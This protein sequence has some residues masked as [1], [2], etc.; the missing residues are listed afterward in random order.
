[1][2]CFFVYFLFQ[3]WQYSTLPRA[4]LWFHLCIDCLFSCSNNLHPR[5]FHAVKIQ[6]RS[7]FIMF[8]DTCNNL[9]PL[10]ENTS[11]SSRRGIQRCESDA[12]SLCLSY[13]RIW[14]KENR[15]RVHVCFKGTMRLLILS[16]LFIVMIH[17]RTSAMQV[18][19]WKMWTC[20]DPELAL[21]FCC[22]R[23]MTGSESGW[24]WVLHSGFW[25]HTKCLL[26]YLEH[27]CCSAGDSC[28]LSC[29]SSSLVW[30]V[31]TQT[32]VIFWHFASR[33]PSLRLKRCHLFCFIS[34]P[35]KSNLF[36]LESFQ[37]C[38]YYFGATFITASE[39]QKERIDWM[40]QI[41]SAIDPIWLLNNSSAAEYIKGK[42]ER[43]KKEKKSF[44]T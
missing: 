43:K 20:D 14:R 41:R 25:G 17:C 30:M 1:M 3:L 4:A 23:H 16:F 32:G 13:T 39:S 10:F 31:V 15:Y 37:T 19:K 38:P 18:E 33:H 9:S 26:S 34:K 22:I 7:F 21:V 12:K 35:I 40:Q 2:S 8:S 36:M 6:L 24:W 44:W 5:R 29:S 27:L 28:S 42:K 11:T